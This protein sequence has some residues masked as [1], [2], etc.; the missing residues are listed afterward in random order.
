[1]K[2]SDKH[3]EELRVAKVNAANEYYK[4]L[5]AYNKERGIK[6]GSL[7]S[8]IIKL[9]KKGLSNKEIVE[10]GYNK[11]YVNQQVM[12]FVKGKRVVKTTVAQYL[13]KKEKK[14]QFDSQNKKA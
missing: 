1:M 3:L 7:S 4:Y 13:P 14:A 11:N 6:A 12:F 8:E 5:K 2:T 10:Q 9:H